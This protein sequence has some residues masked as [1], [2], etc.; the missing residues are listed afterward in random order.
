[1]LVCVCF[2]G[3]YALPGTG[4]V[5]FGLCFGAFAVEGSS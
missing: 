3:A 5:F 1:V 4:T 2:V